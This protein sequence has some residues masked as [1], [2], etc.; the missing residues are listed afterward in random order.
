M[1]MN[2]ERRNAVN[3]TRELLIDLLD[4]G[5]HISDDLWEEVRACLKHYPSEYDLERAAEQAPEI[6]GDFSYYEE[7]K[8][9]VV[10]DSDSD[11]QYNDSVWCNKRSMDMKAITID[12]D[13]SPWLDEEGLTVCIFAGEADTSIDVPFTLEELIDKEIESHTV[14]GKLIE[15]CILDAFVKSLRKAFKYAE[16]RVKELS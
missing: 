16:K 3:R 8:N 14:A 11:V 13:V 5:Y 9:S 4:R 2:Y 1:T 12:F 7:K 6:F 10:L 15:P